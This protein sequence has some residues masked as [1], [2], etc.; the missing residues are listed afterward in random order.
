LKPLEFADKYL[1]PYKVK[2]N[3]V[4]PL[5]CPYC[6]GGKNKDRYTFALNIEKETYNC[7]R[8][9]CNVSGT[10]WKLCK[11]FGETSKNYEIASFSPPQYTKPKA[12]LNK[13]KDRVEA[14][15]NTRKISKSTWQK[16]GVSEVKG[17]IAFPYYENGELVLV[18]YRKPEKYD[19]KGQKAWREKGG[20]PV[21][22]GMDDCDPNGHLIITEGEF[23]TLAIEEAG[24]GNVVSVP[25]GAEDLT[26]VD[27]C[28]E[29]LQQFRQIIIWPDNDKPGQEM[30]RK[31]ISKLGA[32]R[33]LV[34]KSEDKDANEA[35][36]KRGKEGVVED[37]KNAQEV[38]ISGL[39]RLADVVAFDA[40]DAEKIPSSIG[41]INNEVGGYMLGLMS[42]W[43]GINA[44]GKSTFLGQELLTAIDAGYRVCAY[45][46]ELPAALYRYWIDLQAAGQGCIEMVRDKFRDRD[47]PRPAK[48]IVEYIRS[49]Y[50]DKFFLLDAFG[51]VREEELLEVFEYA[52]MRYDCKVFL[53]DN[54]MIVS[55]DAS[56]KDYYRRQSNFAGKLKEFARKHNCHVHLVAHPRKKEGRLTKMDVMGSGDI[57]NLADNVLGVHRYSEKNGDEGP[58]QSVIDIFKNRIFGRQDIEINV[59]FDDL[60]KRFYMVA[61]NEALSKNYGWVKNVKQERV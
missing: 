35:L 8:G 23:D 55:M 11:D 20:K 40:A 5:F 45:S 25:S 38:P 9:S 12:V 14:Y 17:N 7:K 43:T 48:G 39:V 1:R 47:V 4:L 6:Q 31:L 2:G 52:A 36:Y 44:S 26:C 22:W 16:R 3:E 34:V 57:T 30:A 15:L 27:N 21:F 49:W 51:G 59:G 46:G 60:C 13:P 24:V 33:C 41:A 32:W 37:L 50:R 53:V 19:G 42:V 29:W 28:W 58:D 54:L 61:N 18:K 56:E 10:F